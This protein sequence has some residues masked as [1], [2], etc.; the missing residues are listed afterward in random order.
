MRKNYYHHLFQFDPFSL[1]GTHYLIK[2]NI[3]TL[4]NN[5]IQLTPNILITYLTK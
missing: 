3:F 4:V 2:F 1:E 5:K